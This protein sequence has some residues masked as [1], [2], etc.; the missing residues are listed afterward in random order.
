MNQ[1]LAF[2]ENML[3]ERIIGNETP[4]TGKSKAGL[5]LMSLTLLLAGAAV[6]FFLYATY[7]WLSQNFPPSTAA[8]YAGGITLAAAALTSLAGYGLSQYRQYRIRQIKR[9]VRETVQEAL[10]IVTDELEDPVKDNPKTSV[11]LAA[12]AGYVAGDRFL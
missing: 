5:G 2:A 3:M 11:A 12:F 7:I 4:L 9:E 8:Y 1:A 10:T 6:I